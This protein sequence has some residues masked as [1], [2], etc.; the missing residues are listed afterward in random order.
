VQQ[1]GSNIQFDSG[2]PFI[3]LEDD[4]NIS[5][6]F[7]KQIDI[8]QISMQGCQM[9]QSVKGPVHNVTCIRYRLEPV[10]HAFACLGVYLHRKTSQILVAELIQIT[11]GCP[12][13]TAHDVINDNGSPGQDHCHWIQLTGFTSPASGVLN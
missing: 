1:Q 12:P 5:L 10:E 4:E 8:K 3:E 6:C 11:G 13:V 2:A 9:L 7:S